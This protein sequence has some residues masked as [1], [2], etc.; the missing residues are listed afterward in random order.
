MGSSA[1]RRFA[2]AFAGVAALAAFRALVGFWDPGVPA[3]DLGTFASA[4]V[5]ILFAFAAFA[6]LRE[7]RWWHWWFPAA[8]LGCGIA[9]AFLAYKESFWDE[10]LWFGPLEFAWQLFLHVLIGPI[11]LFFAFF[12]GFADPRGPL[13]LLASLAFTLL[14]A[15][16]LRR[17][18]WPMLR[19]AASTDVS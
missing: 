19:G 9:V 1:V 13:Y 12:V 17:R 10:L 3:S 18:V 11:E 7:E 6:V 4:A 2:G 14:G 16:L 8:W 15:E 5:A